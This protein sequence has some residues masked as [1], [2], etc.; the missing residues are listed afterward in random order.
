[1]ISGLQA[2][3]LL[4]HN[5]IVDQVREDEGFNGGGG[6]PIAKRSKMHGGW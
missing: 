2:A 3:F 5:R 1:M 6:T 4:F